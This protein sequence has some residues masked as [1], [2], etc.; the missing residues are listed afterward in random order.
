MRAVRREM[1]Q[2][3]E[4][5]PER[6]IQARERATAAVTLLEPGWSLIDMC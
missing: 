3:V 5:V 1:Q 6:G 4:S 2:C